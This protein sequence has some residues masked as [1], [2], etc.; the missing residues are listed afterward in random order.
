MTSPST[1]T[2]EVN[3][4]AA[5]SP[6]ASSS[7]I[8][9]TMIPIDSYQEADAESYVA[10]VDNTSPAFSCGRQ[11]SGVAVIATSHDTAPAGS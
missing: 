8:Q 4:S 2:A 7:A 9:A 6:G 1:S 10:L 11:F 3:G 5:S